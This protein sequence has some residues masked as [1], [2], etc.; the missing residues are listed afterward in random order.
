[1]SA[2]AVSVGRT[3][4]VAAI[5]RNPP[6]PS[7]PSRTGRS[8]AAVQENDAA[9]AAAGRHGRGVVTVLP[10]TSNVV[11]RVYPF[12]A[13]LPSDDTGLP[14]D[15]KAQAEQVRSVDVR[16]IGRRLGE[17]P[18]LLMSEVDAALRLHLEL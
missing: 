12:Q 18:P 3:G 11:A 9:N 17:V 4:V 7:C 13:L 16:R 6:V 2:L 10:V 14:M 5:D 8:L 15:S 1:V